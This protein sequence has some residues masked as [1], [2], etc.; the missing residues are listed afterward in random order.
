MKDRINRLTQNLSEQQL[1]K[2]LSRRKESS[3]K[4]L[5]NRY[6][7][8]LYLQAWRILQ[9]E[10]ASEDVVQE[11]FID[12]WEKRKFG[13]I[14]NLSAYLYQSVKYKTLMM[15]RKNRITEKHLEVIKEISPVHTFDRALQ[16]KELHE[17]IT[18]H[19]QQ[20]PPRCRE[21]FYKS[22]FEHL[23]NDEIAEQLNISKRTVETH[24]SHALR[25]LRGVKELLMLMIWLGLF[26]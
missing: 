18:Y 23:K 8:T 22:R 1:L 10:K 7:E 4:E 12:L 24:I 11:V 16:V 6:W 15:L 2:N 5:Y 21:V 25:Y 9:D 17:D 26:I 19:L 14:E 3:L 13:D 20:L